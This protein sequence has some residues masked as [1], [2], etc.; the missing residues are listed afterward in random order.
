MYHPAQL[1]IVHRDDRL[2]S[3]SFVG[4][5]D[6]SGG[7]STFVL[8]YGFDDFPVEDSSA[9]SKMF[10]GLYRAL[11]YYRRSQHNYRSTN[12]DGSMYDDGGFTIETDEGDTAT[13]YSKIPMLEAIVDGYDELRIAS[14]L[15]RHHRT[16]RIDYSQIHRYLHEAIFLEDH[17]AFVDEMV[18]PTPVLALDE[19]ALVQMFCFVYSEVKRALTEP[20]APEVRVQAETFRSRHLTTDSLLFE[21]VRGHERTIEA[22]KEVLYEIDRQ[23]KFKNRDYWHFYDAVEAFLYGRAKESE[24]GVY[25]GITTFSL[26]WEDMC[27]AWVRENA[28]PS[29]QFADASRYSNQTIGGHKVFVDTKF[30][31]PFYFEMEGAK[32]YLRP[33][34]VRYIKEPGLREYLDSL[35][36]IEDRG[37]SVRIRLA[38]ND[39]QAMSW[40]KG[41]RSKIERPGF[42]QP[43]LN[44]AGGVFRGV[45]A[46]DVDKAISELAKKDD[47]SEESWLITDFKC[48][49]WVIYSSPALG[50]KAKR[51]VLKQ[52]TYEYALQI[53][54]FENGGSMSTTS[55]LCVPFYFADPE[56]PVGQECDTSL[57]HHSLRDQGIEVFKANFP[58]ILD[59]YLEASDQ[60]IT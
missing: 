9:V 28:W 36:D 30:E 59:T 49:P 22:L 47:G 41:L 26:V 13:L 7:R 15:Y 29:V 40:Y 3:D 58:L 8:P 4:V 34:L 2:R 56:A 50:G 54:A 35:F 1:E 44:K 21:D 53:Y 31:S 57:L 19:T 18:L 23:T 11:R 6:G 16:E 42:R 24:E 60:N 14:I 33:D 10:F 12:R 43:S 20:V 45:R 55:Q 51:D 25:W 46:S 27:L 32:R 38:K 48:V 39:R 52:V 5:C 37:S 17:T